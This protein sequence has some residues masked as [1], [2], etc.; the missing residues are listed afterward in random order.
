V[1][2]RTFTAP[3][4]KAPTIAFF[5]PA[6]LNNSFLLSKVLTTIGLSIASVLFT[7]WMR[8]MASDEEMVGGRSAESVTP[9]R[10]E[11]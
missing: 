1:T 5:N 8:A 7:C 3:F 9:F 6:S 4:H 2:R 10:S 11:R